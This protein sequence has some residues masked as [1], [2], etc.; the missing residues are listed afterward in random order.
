MTQKEAQAV[1]NVV[2]ST[3]FLNSQ[4]VYALI[5]PGATYSFIVK[6]FES[7]LKVKPIKLDKGFIINTPLRDVVCV[8]YMYKGV[9]V[10]IKG[11]DVDVNLTPLEFHDFDL[12][13]G[14][15]WLSEH[16]AQIDSF[17]DSDHSGNR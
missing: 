16:K 9:M 11:L 10:K 12:I 4:Q 13:L 15:D 17:A 6:R 2:A 3:L 14:M 8:H 1:L 7:K 5:D